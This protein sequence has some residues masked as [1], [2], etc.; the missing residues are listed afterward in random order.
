M[1]R[2]MTLILAVPVVALGMVTTAH[3]DNTGNTYL[4]DLPRTLGEKPDHVSMTK[5]GTVTPFNKDVYDTT[6]NIKAGKLS[7]EFA[8]WFGNGNNPPMDPVGGAALVGGFTLNPGV[9]LKPGYE[10]AWVQTVISSITGTMARDDWHLPVN[11]AGE[12]PDSHPNDPTY[13]NSRLP[14]GSTQ[15]PTIGY[16][17][18]PARPMT[19][20]MGNPIASDWLAELALVCIADEPVNDVIEFKVIGSFLWGWSVDPV[21]P[22]GINDFTADPKPSFWSSPT[23]SFLT[24]M[25]DFYDANGGGGGGPGGGPV[26]GDDEYRFTKCDNCFIPGPSSAAVFAFACIGYCRR[27]R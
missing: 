26:V 2:S 18:F 7:F 16:Q 20:N 10:L 5:Y 22:Y 15:K 27:R 3:A 25:N 24:T 11:N 21:A 13:G 1:N 4:P 14:D 8:T 23:G 19:D 6:K 9:T 17:D 12:Y